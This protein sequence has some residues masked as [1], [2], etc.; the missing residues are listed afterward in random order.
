MPMQVS[1]G[2]AVSAGLRYALRAGYQIVVR[3]D[4]DGQH[5]APLVT[6]LLEPVL[7]GKADVTIGSRFV[8]ELDTPW[9]LRRG[10][11]YL[12]GRILTVLTGQQVTDPTSGLWIFG[13]R[14]LRMLRVHHPSGYPEPEL[15]MFLSRNRL[16]VQEVQ[17]RMR[18]RVAGYTSLTPRRMGVTLARLAL[19]LVV[20]P[21]RSSVTTPDD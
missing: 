12:L 6:R 9:T 7:Q 15:I 4:G 10:C 2:A 1:L 20:V 17:V 19:L 21:L 3:V 5:P 11:Q 16:R 8:S 13:P 14:A 18:D